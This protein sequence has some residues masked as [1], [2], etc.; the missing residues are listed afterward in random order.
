[1]QQ[2]RKKR[3]AVTMVGWSSWSSCNAIVKWHEIGNG[4]MVLL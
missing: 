4:S 1:M 3:D 2:T